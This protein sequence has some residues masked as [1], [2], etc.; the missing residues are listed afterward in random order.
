MIVSLQPLLTNET[1]PLGAA[2]RPPT[3]RPSLVLRLRALGSIPPLPLPR[4]L[5]A[6]PTLKAGWLRLK[7]R[8]VAQALLLELRDQLPELRVRLPLL[9][10][11]A[12]LPRTLCLALVLLYR[13]RWIALRWSLLLPFP[14]P[15]SVPFPVRSATGTARRPAP[16]V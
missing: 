10:R 8:L 15:C 6:R 5:V 3:V 2:P 7:L 11:V 4:R 9:L 13:R 14:L 12:M 16:E 1:K